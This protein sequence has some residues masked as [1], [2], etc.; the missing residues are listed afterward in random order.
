MATSFAG[1]AAAALCRLM[2]QLSRA[3]PKQAEHNLVAVVGAKMERFGVWCA[4]LNTVLR[5]C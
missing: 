1:G 5:M 2:W 4:L 3:S